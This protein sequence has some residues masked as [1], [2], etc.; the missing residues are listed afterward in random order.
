MARAHLAV[1]VPGRHHH[2][3]RCR[4][5]PC[6]RRGHD[7]ATRRSGRGACRRQV[8]RRKRASEHHQG[9]RLPSKCQPPV[10]YPPSGCHGCLWMHCVGGL[11]G[12][13]VGGWAVVSFFRAFKVNTAASRRRVWSPRYY[14][15]P[16]EARSERGES[17]DERGEVFFF[18]CSRVCVC[19]CRLLPG[20]PCLRFLPPSV[21]QFHSTMQ[22][23][24]A[25][26]C[27][28]LFWLARPLRLR[29]LLLRRIDRSKARRSKVL[30]LLRLTFAAQQV[31]FPSHS[32]FF[33]TPA[34]FPLPTH[35]TRS[36]TH[37]QQHATGSP[38]RT[39]GRL[40]DRSTNQGCC[41]KR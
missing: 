21:D 7:D 9:Q 5:P 29:L 2:Q 4:R 14:H 17:I 10:S 13:W 16:E 37:T 1:P 38:K 28:C 26:S 18:F 6:R 25:L 35:T 23:G 15:H 32:L 39:T 22:R 33:L 41:A 8:E 20:R 27:L 30:A 36:H 40:F 24:A 12:G 3:P 11:V 19:R 31:H 34:A